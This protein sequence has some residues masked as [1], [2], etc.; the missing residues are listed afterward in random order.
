MDFEELTPAIRKELDCIEYSLTDQL[1]EGDEHMAQTYWHDQVDAG[2]RLVQNDR[3]V[4]FG[5]KTRHCMIVAV[6]GAIHDW[7]A[8]EEPERYPGQEWTSDKIARLGNKIPQDEA[9]EL[10]PCIVEQGF[11]WRP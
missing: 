8:Y 10:F 7:A 5:A 4:Y 6:I 9:E 11:T 3:V 1:D 2:T